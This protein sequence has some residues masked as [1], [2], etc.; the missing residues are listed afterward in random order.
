M[1]K[2][3]GV[4][5][6]EAGNSGTAD[7]LVPLR[8]LLFFLSYSLSFFLFFL[9]SF[10]LSPR[11]QGE[12]RRAAGRLREA[13]ADGEQDWTVHDLAMIHQGSMLVKVSSSS[14]RAATQRAVFTR[15]AVPRT[16]A[17]HQ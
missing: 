16:F 7:R 10:F 15:L 4:G 9:L 2:V 8:C 11:Q 6:E 5:R 1:R 12:S 17:G 13:A 14:S 3:E